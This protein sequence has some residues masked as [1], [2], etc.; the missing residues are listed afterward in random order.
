[1][2]ERARL[3]DE[4]IEAIESLPEPQ[5]AV[6]VAHEIDGR[7]FREMAEQSG[8]S[9]NTLLSRKHSAVQFLRKR[10]QAAHDNLN[11]SEE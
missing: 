6:F 9:V 11:T 1:M 5:R 3:F 8:E 10:L 4:L 2:Y 7:S